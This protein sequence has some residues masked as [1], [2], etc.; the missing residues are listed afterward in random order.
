MIL[1]AISFAYSLMF[2]HFLVLAVLFGADSLTKKEL[3][4]T[5]RT[6]LAPPGGGG[7]GADSESALDRFTRDLTLA[8]RQGKLDPVICRDEEIR[9]CVHILSRRTKNNPVLIGQFTG[10]G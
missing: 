7:F 4:E 5:M 1:L 8:A 2:E 10:S 6:M 9:R 3:E